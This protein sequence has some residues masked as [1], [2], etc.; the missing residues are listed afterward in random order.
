[1]AGPIVI[2]LTPTITAGARCVHSIDPA[3]I[4]AIHARPGAYYINLHTATFPAGAVRG[5]LQG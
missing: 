5:Q 3:V 2:H 4:R 1:V